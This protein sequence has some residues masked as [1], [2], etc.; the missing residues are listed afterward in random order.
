MLN[1]MSITYWSV[2]TQDSCQI[3]CHLVTDAAPILQYS[4][5]STTIER[6]RRRLNVSPDLPIDTDHHPEFVDS[7]D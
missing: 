3:L 4:K 6:F 5:D 2:L 1:I 7:D